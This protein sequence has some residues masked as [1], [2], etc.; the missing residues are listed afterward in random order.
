L[1]KLLQERVMELNLD[2]LPQNTTVEIKRFKEMINSNERNPRIRDMVKQ[3]KVID[4]WSDDFTQKV[5][6]IINYGDWQIH[7]RLFDKIFERMN[8]EDFEWSIA[9][10]IFELN[11]VKTEP[12]FELTFI[13]NREGRAREHSF[14]ALKYLYEIMSF[15]RV[16]LKKNDKN[17]F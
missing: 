14:E 16:N 15:Y 8:F 13:E 7:H 5:E 11:G 10:P 6:T 12:D 1:E 9:K 4:S 2:E 17:R 3:I